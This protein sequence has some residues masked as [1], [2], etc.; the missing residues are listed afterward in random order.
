MNILLSTDN[1]Y[2]MPTGVL[3]HSICHHNKNV[4]YYILV[5]P[6]FSTESKRALEDIAVGYDCAIHFLCVDL[7]KLKY[8][9]VGREDQPIHITKAAYFRLFVAELL[10]KD[11]NR[12]LYLDGDIIVRKSLE[13]LWDTDL[14][15]YS[16]GVVHD[17]NELNHCKS[18]R[19]PYPMNKG[20]FNSGVLL[21]NLNYWR[22]HNLIQKFMTFAQE[23]EDI[24]T[25]HDQ[26]VLNCVLYD[27]L[28]WL[29]LTY[30]FENGFL[31]SSDYISFSPAIQ[32]E[33]DKTKYDPAIIHFASAD[34]PWK[35]TCYHPYVGVWRHYWRKSKWKHD[36][37][38]GENPVS[39]KD[40]IRM[41][42]LRHCL[43]LPKYMYQNCILK[44]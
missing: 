44:K 14:S 24:L 3:M 9:P 19:L 35:I 12:V 34:K 4:V 17:V 15:G 1:N 2:V 7:A 43:Y 16:T 26:D 37:L 32:N 23:N 18:G 22:E 11:I 27:S 13:K 20:Y 28:K 41:F 8:M 6:C 25:L 21:I 33:I 10:P 29:P 38:Y 36:K 42:A 39:I 30:N 40:K 31:L 5:D